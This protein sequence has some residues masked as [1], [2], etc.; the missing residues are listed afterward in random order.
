MKCG[1]VS[2]GHLHF[3]LTSVVVPA[4]VAFFTALFTFGIQERRLKREYMLDFMAEK[5]ARE[6]LESKEW[7]KRSFTTIKARLGGF[8]DDELRKV[9]VRA[10]AV[11]FKG[12]DGNEELWGLLKRNEAD[13]D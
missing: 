4:V 3:V 11:R 2:F 9:L 12:K 13:P 10:G 8:T 5:A 1:L 6:L 7:K